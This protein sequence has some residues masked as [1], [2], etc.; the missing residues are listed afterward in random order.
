MTK[1]SCCD[2]DGEGECDGQFCDNCIVFL[3]QLYQEPYQEPYQ[4]ESDSE[5]DEDFV[6]LFRGDVTT[7]DHLGYCSGEENETEE[8]LDQLIGI[9][10]KRKHEMFE[11]VKHIKNICDSSYLHS[12]DIFA[13]LYEANTS[14]KILVNPSYS[15]G[16]GSYYCK[17]S[18]TGHR[19]EQWAI[20]DDCVN[21]FTMEESKN[22]EIVFVEPPRYT[23]WAKTF[24]NEIFR[25]C[26]WFGRTP[27]FY[28]ISLRTLFMCVARMRIPLSKDVRKYLTHAFV[29]VH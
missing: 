13:E 1:C 10:V 27:E 19:H 20:L 25:K 2:S 26:M 8:E 11:T 6:V 14:E 3:D 5:S 12:T 4:P 24:M 29:D 7:Y 22:Y 16:Y 15:E 18:V 28:A 21:I 17:K 9:R 23:T